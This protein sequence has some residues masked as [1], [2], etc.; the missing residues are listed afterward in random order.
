VR[1]PLSD[2]LRVSWVCVVWSLASGTASLVVGLTAGSLSLGGLGASVLVDVI[3]SAV[4]IWRFRRERGAGEFP[5]AAERRAQ[6]VAALGLVVI[7]AALGASS[8]QHLVTAAH[9][10]TPALAL[11]LAAA[12]LVVLPLLARWKYRV[13]EAVGSL[14]LRTDAH[15]TMVGTSTSALTLVGLGLDRGFGWWWADAAAAMLIAVVALDQG[16]RSMSAVGSPPDEP[17][18]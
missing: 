7:A 14:A 8:I 1:D 2:A 9:P 10:E 13:A 5:E 18:A 11:G 16:R 17:K 15:I 4:L 12:N 6:L 3:S